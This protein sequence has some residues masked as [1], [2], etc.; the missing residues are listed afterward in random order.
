MS[1]RETRQTKNHSR[2]ATLACFQKNA[3]V[4]IAKSMAPMVAWSSARMEAVCERRCQ[5]HV[6]RKR[7]A[8]TVSTHVIACSDPA[9]PGRH[10]VAMCGPDILESAAGRQTCREASTR[11]RQQNVKARLRRNLPTAPPTQLA[12]RKRL[13]CHALRPRRVR[14]KTV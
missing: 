14:M 3:G 1:P 6:Q 12:L 5:S 9:T 10:F 7:K 2:L 4:N 11:T 13:R 8:G